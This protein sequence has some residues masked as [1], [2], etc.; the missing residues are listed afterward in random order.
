MHRF[1][2][3]ILFVAALM[4]PLAS[5]CTDSGSNINPKAEVKEKAPKQIEPGSGGK[6]APK[7]PGTGSV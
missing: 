5:G 6:G 3:L 1:S 4:L 7:G 2:I